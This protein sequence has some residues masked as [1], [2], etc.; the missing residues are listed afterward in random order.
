MYNYFSFSFKTKVG[1]S[2][3]RKEK[4]NLT[5]VRLSRFYQCLAATKLIFFIT[6]ATKLIYSFQYWSNFNYIFTF[7]KMVFI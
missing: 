1:C 3:T 5:D 4:D 7:I 2:K 6:S